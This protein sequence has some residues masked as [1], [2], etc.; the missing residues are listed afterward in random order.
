MSVTPNKPQKRSLHEIIS[1]QPAVEKKTND[2]TR[3][4]R[5]SN[6]KVVSRFF[7]LR[8]DKK[9]NQRGTTLTQGSQQSQ[10]ECTIITDESVDVSRPLESQET[11]CG[12]QKTIISVEDDGSYEI[13]D[14][15]SST[16][17]DSA[18]RKL[19]R[20][21]GSNN[22]RPRKDVDRFLAVKSADEIAHVLEESALSLAQESPQ[23]GE[24]MVAFHES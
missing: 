24:S 20:F 13:R 4:K 11:S 18:V 5:T 10:I 6:V 1:S 2:E 12:T 19:A 21:I 16:Y 8:S 23:S 17:V 14:N 3:L 9:L 22:D 15:G 7:D